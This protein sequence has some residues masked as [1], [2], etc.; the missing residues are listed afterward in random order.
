[1]RN[2]AASVAALRIEGPPASTAARTT[3]LRDM[4]ARHGEVEELHSMNSV[5]L[6]REIRDVAAL[7]SGGMV[8]RLSVPPAAGGAVLAGVAA[9]GR[10]DGYLDWGGGLV[11]LAGPADETLAHGIRT[12]AQ[13][14]G[15]HATLMVAP[16]E[17]KSVVPVFHPQPAERFRLTRRIKEGFDHLGLLNPGRMYSGI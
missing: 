11:W 17:M 12:A 13:A 15:G 1:V 4:L 9:E 14:A 8:W 6:W 5:N 2:A 10:L 7:L 16:P 3:A